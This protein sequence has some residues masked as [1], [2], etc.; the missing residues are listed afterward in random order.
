MTRCVSPALILAAACLLGGPARA[1]DY[2]RLLVE[3]GVS[4]HERGLYREALGNFISA[5]QIDPEDPKAIYWQARAAQGL[6]AELRAQLR[7]EGLEIVRG[8]LD[9]TERVSLAG[10]LCERGHRAFKAGE[11]VKAAAFYEE[12]RRTYVRHTCSAPG[13][14][15]TRR[16]LE[17]K[18]ADGK[19]SSAELQT[20]ADFRVSGERAWNPA[21]LEPA[22]PAL[23]A[24][25]EAPAAAA[26]QPRPSLPRVAPK[27]P[28]RPEASP[29]DISA[30]DDFYLLAVADYMS[31][32]SAGTLESLRES[33][34]L[35]PENAR[36]KKLLRRIEM[37]E[38]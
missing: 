32:E 37:V 28:R 35:N 22:A 38:K 14:S 17:K 15:M 4:Q 34:R 11:L 2:S 8:G 20:L 25:P 16:A 23:S 19:V 6:G 31:N 26:V 3:S 30:S 18:V 24:Q 10:I 36:A 9:W 13:L 1:D 27:P 7:K 21:K 12:S 5:L 29:Q 33:L